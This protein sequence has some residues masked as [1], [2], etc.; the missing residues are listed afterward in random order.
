MHAD[1]RAWTLRKAVEPC[2]S[3]ERSAGSSLPGHPIAGSSRPWLLVVG[4]GKSVLP[5]G[6]RRDVAGRV[7]GHA[8]IVEDQADVAVEAAHFLGKTGFVIGEVKE[9]ADGEAAQA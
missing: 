8:Q 9:D 2:G 3:A 6:S 5:L 4:H 7:L 1:G